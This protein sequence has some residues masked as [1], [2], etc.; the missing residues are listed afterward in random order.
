MKLILNETV[1]RLGKI[2]DIVD[3]SDGYARNYLIP[4]GLGIAT[5]PRNI[6]AF[7]HLKKVIANKIKKEKRSLEETAKAI[8]ALSLS[9]KV[10]VNEEGK[11]FGSVTAKE[12]AELIL[13]QGIQID[14]DNILLE[15]PIKETGSFYLPV[16]MPHDITAQIKVDVTASTESEDV[17]PEPGS[18]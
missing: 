8:S 16:K 14:K 10:K 7:E 4:K 11:L 15:K 17:S 5:T 18:T 13:A 3:V 9:V 6:I 2:G 12:I 1:Q